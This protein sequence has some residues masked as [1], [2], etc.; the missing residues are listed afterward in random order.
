MVKVFEIN[1]P[2]LISD[3]IACVHSIKAHKTFLRVII[4]IK[5]D[6]LVIKITHVAK[7]IDHVSL[8]VPSWYRCE[9]G[10]ALYVNLL[11]K[12]SI[13]LKVLQEQE[14]KLLDTLLLSVEDRPSEEVHDAKVVG[15][16]VA[17]YRHVI[18]NR[19]DAVFVIEVLDLCA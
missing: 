16:L 3:R 7:R 6:C 2:I 12:I 14:F 4:E 9:V 8:F 18:F 15:Y 13:P 1:D 17:I 10:D 5:A 11:A 19:F